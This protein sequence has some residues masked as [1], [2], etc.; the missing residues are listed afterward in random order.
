M[1]TCSCVNMKGGVMTETNC[2]EIKECESFDH[3]KAC[4]LDESSFSNLAEF[5]KMFGDSTRIKIICTLLN[6]EMCVGSIADLLE[7]SQSSVSHQLRVLKTSRLVKC[8]KDG[9]QSFYSL[10]DSHIS[11]IIEMGLEHIN[12]R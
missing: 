5:Y 7:M 11:N 3:I 10:D 6:G 9:K 2:C 1:N 8:R 4:M 12:E